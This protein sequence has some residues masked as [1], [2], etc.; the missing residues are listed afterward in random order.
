MKF[1]CHG[2]WVGEMSPTRP[3]AAAVSQMRQADKGI[4]GSG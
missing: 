4:S 2:P 1:C 3:R